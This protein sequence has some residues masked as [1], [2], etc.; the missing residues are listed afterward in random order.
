MK[1]GIMI[2]IWIMIFAVLSAFAT[3]P[4]GYGTISGVVFVG[5]MLVAWLA[6]LLT[7]ATWV[8]QKGRS[9]RGGG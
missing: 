3:A 5:G 1:H 9:T 8:A 2:G 7:V 4:L 6:G